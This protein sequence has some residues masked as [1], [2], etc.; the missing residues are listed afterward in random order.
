[1]AWNFLP[2]DLSPIDMGEV[3]DR[4]TIS[5]EHAPATICTDLHRRV[6]DWTPARGC[7]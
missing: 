6:L 4:R 1:M 3:N 5:G 2:P 7:A